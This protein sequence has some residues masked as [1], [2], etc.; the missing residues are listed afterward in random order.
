[1]GV[2][3]TARAAVTLLFFEATPQGDSILIEWGTASEVDVFGFYIQRAPYVTP[4]IADCADIPDRVR[5]SNL[6]PSEGDIIGAF[7]D[8]TDTSAVAEVTYYYCLEAVEVDSD[9][10]LHG[11][12]SATLSLPFSTHL[13]LVLKEVSTSDLDSITMVEIWSKPG[14]MKMY[15]RRGNLLD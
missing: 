12:I 7:Y 1:L 4:E 15:E 3:V 8:Y 6:I 9:F 10:E 5:I 2:S 11:P 14:I 13:P